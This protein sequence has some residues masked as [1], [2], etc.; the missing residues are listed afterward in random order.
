VAADALD[1]LVAEFLSQSLPRNRWT[2]TAHLSV[3]AW[4]VHRFGAAD[5]IMRLRAGIRALNDRHGTPNTATNGYHETITVAYVRLIAEF[6]VAFEPSIPLS[7]RVSHLVAGTLSEKSVLLKFWSTD[8]LMS[9]AAR[10]AWVAPDLAPLA[11]PSDAV[12]A[13][14]GRMPR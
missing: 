8:L 11:L 13:S 14:S 3:G 4:H 7:R 2:H 1:I 5:A 9:A 10:A 12:P 6:L